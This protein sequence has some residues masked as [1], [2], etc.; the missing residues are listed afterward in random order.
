[1]SL[2]RS[3]RP[4]PA[5]AFGFSVLPNFSSS[6][7]AKAL[8]QDGALAGAGYAV[9]DGFAAARRRAVSLRLLLLVVLFA[10]EALVFSVWLDN[11]ALSAR[12]GIL[13]ALVAR[14][15]AWTLRGVFGSAALFF[16]FAYLK[17]K[18]AL[19]ALSVESARTP[20][21]GGLLSA[22]VAAMAAFSALSWALYGNH[23]GPVSANL[24]AALWLT[25]GTAG[26]IFAALAFVPA[27]QWLRLLRRTGYLWLYA[28]AGVSVACVVGSYFRELWAPMTGVTFA[29]VELLLRPFVSG[30][31]ADPARMTLGSA[32]F[33]VQIA[34]E[35]SGFEG[36][37]L[38]LAFGVIW[39][40]VFRR[41][42]RF[43]QALLL[44]PAGV[45]TIFLLNA[46]RLVVLILIGDAGAPQ[47][48]LGGFHSQAGW[49]AFNAV[50]LGF[51]VAARRV[52][53]VTTS[54]KAPVGTSRG[55]ASGPV[56][57]LLTANPTATYLLPFLSILAAGALTT[58][59]SGGFEWLYPMR[60]FAAAGT[61]WA[62]RKGYS[63]LDWRPGWSGM[64]IGV[65]AF[66]IWIG[67]DWLVRGAAGD[68]MPEALAA[69][70]APLRM[71]WIGF[72]VVAA[73]IT[74]P[75]AE[76]LAFRGFL[77]RRFL[78]ADFE[79]LSPRCF[80]WLGLAVSSVAFGLLH[81]NLWL[82]GILAG[83]LYA[84]ALIRR[85]KI[86]DAVAAHA[87]TNALLAAYVLV[88][89]QWHLW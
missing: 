22:H 88:F 86:G 81:G 70:P 42:C 40:C 33:S 47:I 34:P 18:A 19:T 4:N 7:P 59:I 24:T 16:T 57:R 51:S 10:A 5:G 39:L 64:F 80:T 30:M 36:V 29:L 23:A 12:P 76:E 26:A 62:L 43:P 8:G 74:V 55:V 54:A 73:M 14:W 65:A 37:G 69:S 52:P 72:R 67:A 27:S 77:L 17:N 85:G 79:T 3:T 53:W 35:C 45:A 50:A 21:S 2:F 6:E 11:A 20:L 71:T 58:A 1:M 68:A 84:W 75:I 46:V 87:T 82:P 9:L 83:L 56:D 31:V 44:L 78:S 49:L 61:L 15:G 89:H 13:P 25:A 32:K 38:I 28:S 66:A 63:Q 41:E 60:F 48:A